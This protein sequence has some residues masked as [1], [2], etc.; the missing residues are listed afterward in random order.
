MAYHA[1]DYEDLLKHVYKTGVRS[2]DRTGV[3]TYRTFGGTMDF[4]LLGR[5]NVQDDGSQIVGGIPLITTKKV[6]FSWVIHELLWFLDGDTNIRTLLLNGVTIWSEWPFKKYLI[7]TDQTIPVVNS[8]EWKARIKEYEARI[9]ADEDFAERYGDIGPMYG[10]QWRNWN[11][12]P[13][14]P[15]ID[16]LQMLMETLADK[17]ESRRMVVNAWNVEELPEMDLP[18][19]HALFDVNVIDGGLYLGM[20]QRSA[21]MFLGVPL[22]IASY[23]VLAHMLAQQTGYEAREFAWRGLDVHLYTNHVEQ[24][25]LLLSRD[26]RPLP[27]LK[28]NRKPESIF[29]YKADDFEVVGYNPHPYIHAEIA[30]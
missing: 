3:G 4:S 1:V 11:G 13:G 29:D 25:E 30:V 7:A 24:T 20:V 6:N 19:C 18:P 15:G 12:K 2:G 17:P 27:M 23:S 10:S 28:L 14:K 22:N 16:Q 8:P 9:V 5:E 21:D 26:Q